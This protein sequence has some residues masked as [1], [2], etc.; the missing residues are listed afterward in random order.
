[1]IITGG[2]GNGFALGVNSE[3][4]AVVEAISSTVEHHINHHGKAAYN[5]VFTATSEAAV[6]RC[7]YY[8]KND[9]D[10]DMCIEG[11][12]LNIDKATTITVQLNN[13]GDPDSG[14]AITPAI[15]NAGAVASASGT[16][17]YG[18]DLGNAGATLTG[19][20]LSEQFVYTG[21]RES[22]YVNF[23]QD[24]IL[25]K[26]TVL[27]LWTS[28]ATTLVNATVVFNYHAEEGS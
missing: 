1:M 15:L 9:D 23:E 24:I 22:H 19:G 13:I 25:P 4:R 10:V 18:A 7:F 17:E 27:M 28:A 20:V 12:W 6:T 11:L 2:T 26:N 16:F 3:N 8:M 5:V 21:A 14:T